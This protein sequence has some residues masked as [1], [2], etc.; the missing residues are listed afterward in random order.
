MGEGREC[1]WNRKKQTT[2]FP[3]KG[4]EQY[5]DVTRQTQVDVTLGYLSR[6]TTPNPGLQDSPRPKPG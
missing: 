2:I 6:P 3:I 1:F 4:I 5:L